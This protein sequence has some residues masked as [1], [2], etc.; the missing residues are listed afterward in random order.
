MLHPA[1][2]FA[3]QLS[4]PGSSCPNDVM[5][6]TT[7]PPAMAIVERRSARESGRGAVGRPFR[8]EVGVGTG[9]GVTVAFSARD[10]VRARPA[11][12]AAAAVATAAD[13]VLASESLAG[14][15]LLAGDDPL[16]LSGAG[17]AGAWYARLPRAMVGWAVVGAATDGTCGVG[18]VI[19]P[20]KPA[21]HARASALRRMRIDLRMYS[22]Q[23]CER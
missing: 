6:P 22:V 19:L 17:D 23:S 12:S 3:N 20:V 8:A 13:D 16:S 11:G 2:E 5:P 15:D 9:P 18:E 14:D 4:V 7:R 21:R 1:T 10:R